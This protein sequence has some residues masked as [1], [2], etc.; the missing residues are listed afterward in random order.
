M[1]G[2]AMRSPYMIGVWQESLPK[3]ATFVNQHYLGDNVVQIVPDKPFGYWLMLRV[4]GDQ[5]N[6]IRASGQA[7]TPKMTVIP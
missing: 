2:V 6:A 1:G 4:T 3:L 7:L 5:A